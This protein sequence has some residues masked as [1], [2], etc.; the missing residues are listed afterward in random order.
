MTEM[1]LPENRWHRKP[2]NTCVFFA[3]YNIH[4]I[5]HNLYNYNIFCVRERYN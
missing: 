3:T 1:I 2:I 5:V 4:T